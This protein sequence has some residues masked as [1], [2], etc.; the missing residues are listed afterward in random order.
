MT[1]TTRLVGYFVRVRVRELLDFGVDMVSGAAVPLLSEGYAELVASFRVNRRL[2]DIARR[3]GVDAVLTSQDPTVVALYKA[4]R[5]FATQAERAAEGAMTAQVLSAFPDHSVLG[6]ELGEHARRAEDGDSAIRW[7][8][9]PVDGTTAMLRT[10]VAEAFEISLPDPPPAFGISIGVLDGGN[11]VGGL[12]AELRPRSDAGL[13]VTRLWLGGVGV[14]ATC[15]GESVSAAPPVPFDR[16]ALGCTV[17]E[18][19]FHSEVEWRD[20]Q[21]LEEGAQRCVT[22]QNCI[23]FMRLL[24]PC[25]GVNVVFERDLKAPDA[26]ALVPILGAGGVRV[27]D[28]H[29]SPLQFGPKEIDDEYVVLAAHPTLHAEAMQRIRSGPSEPSTFHQWRRAARGVDVA[30]VI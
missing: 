25:G 20:F 30:K 24:D 18:V 8:L 21:A 4:N 5:E 23:G 10:A 29:G 3:S 26:A 9:D 19:M 15:N 2:A 28:P 12:V 13:T 22:G 17:P 7:A 27:T 1:L 6:E 14:P 11:T 16:A